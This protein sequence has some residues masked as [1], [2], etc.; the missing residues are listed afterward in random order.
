MTPREVDLEALVEKP[1]AW[2]GFG[3]VVILAAL[4]VAPF[5]WWFA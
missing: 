3:L 4:V 2:L 1:P 5:I